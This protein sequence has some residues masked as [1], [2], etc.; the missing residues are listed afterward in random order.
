MF[1]SLSP[2]HSR[3]TKY[4]GTGGAFRGS[5]TRPPA[6]PRS[7]QGKVPIVRLRIVVEIGPNFRPSVHS[8][9]RHE[10]QSHL[11]G[12]H[13]ADRVEVSFV[14]TVHVGGQQ[15]AVFG[16]QHLKPTAAGWS[17]SW[18]KRAR[19]RCKAAFTAGMLAFMIVPTS[20]RSTR[21]RPSKLRC[22]AGRRAAA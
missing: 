5:L 7:R 16:R 15:R 21:A 9:T 4:S 17:P 8:D 20:R 6:F 3:S 11:I 18:R 12:E 10:V 22:S 2:C 1:R 13:V 14:E 19:P